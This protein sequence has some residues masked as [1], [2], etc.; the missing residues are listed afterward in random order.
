MLEHGGNL[1][2][3]AVKY[4]IPLSD[5]LD[6]STGINPNGWPVPPIPV[7]CWQRLP[8]DDDGLVDAARA[9]Y[10]APHCLPVAGSQAA[11]LA[12]PALRS[13]CRVGMISPSYA[14]HA[15]AWQRAGHALVTLDANDIRIDEI[16][17]LLLVHPNNP[18]GATYTRAQLLAWHAQLAHRGGWLIIDE[19]YIDA[20]PSHSLAADTNLDGLIV[21]R[22]LGKFF[23]LAGA[24]VGFVLAAPDLLQMLQNVIGPWT[25]SHAAR[26]LA[27]QALQ[28][29]TWQVRARQ[30]LQADALRL[31]ALLQHH[32]LVPQGGVPLF[33]WLTHPHAADLHHCLAQN[34][35]LMR[36]FAEPAS[37]RI[38]LPATAADWGKL[39]LGL[40]TLTELIS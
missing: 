20:D 35:I 31:S 18:T 11:L 17:V 28:D 4:G 1:R 8:E 32:N 5:W 27:K 30:Q 23:G 3:V 24:R 29:S 19:A 36:L 26:W 37:L 14:E 12:L 10:L 9:Y 15:H 39:S 6:L 34:G 40:A 21:L 7:D 33:Q 2:Q 38:G 25:V 13:R 22:S 16:D